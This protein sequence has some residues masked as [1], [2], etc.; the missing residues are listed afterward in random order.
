[1]VSSARPASARR[2]DVGQRR[3]AK[4]QALGRYAALLC[5]A[6]QVA[7]CRWLIGASLNTLCGTAFNIW[8][9]SSHS[10]AS[11]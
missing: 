2:D 6:A 5:F 1:M 9:Q 4:H 3:R 10:L 7:A 11:A 8:H